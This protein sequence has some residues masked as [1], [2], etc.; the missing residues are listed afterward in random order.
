[1]I[2]EE[3]KNII[4]QSDFDV[5][6]GRF[7]YTKVSSRP[8][9]GEH[10]MVTEDGD[11]ITVVTQEGKIGQ[12]DLIERNKDTYSL[13]ALN[14]SVPFYSV[15]FL[16]EVSKAIAEKGV[17]ILLVSTYSKDYVMVKEN[18]LDSTRKILLSMGLSEK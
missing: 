15:G 11:E 10:F 18:K 12:L 16:A 7:V 5:I 1:M 17:N 2:N 8:T 13:I 3:L 4:S 9:T 14:V 6:D